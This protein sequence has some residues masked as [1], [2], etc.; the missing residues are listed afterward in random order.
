MDDLNTTGQDLQV[1]MFVEECNKRFRFGTVNNGP[2]R[3]R[4]F[5]IYFDQE[6]DYRIETNTDYKLKMVAEYPITSMRPRQKDDHLNEMEKS[7]FALDWKRN[8]SV[9][10]LLFQLPST[11]RSW[12][13]GKPSCRANG[14]NQKTEEVR[15]LDSLQKAK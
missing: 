13:D 4:F 5:G 15:H 11:K 2:G 1:K 8:I 9:M 12:H 7:A 10:L 3:L 6:S 14:N